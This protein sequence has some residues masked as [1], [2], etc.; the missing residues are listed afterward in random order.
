MLGGVVKGAM[1]A[2]TLAF[3]AVSD[4]GYSSVAIL[5]L[6]SDSLFLCSC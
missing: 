6:C 2:E 4:P 1:A 5:T 3:A